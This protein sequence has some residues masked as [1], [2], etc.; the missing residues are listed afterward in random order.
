MTGLNQ[1]QKKM[2]KQ[3][4]MTRFVVAKK[5]KGHTVLAFAVVVVSE[6]EQMAGEALLWFW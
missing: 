4:T 2:R 3:K 6:V 1:S 5:K